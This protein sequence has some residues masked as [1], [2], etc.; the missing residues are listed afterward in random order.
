MGAPE[1]LRPVTMWGHP[2]YNMII[3]IVEGVPPHIYRPPPGRWRPG[4]MWGHP[5]NQG[6]NAIVITLL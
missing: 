3:P 1:Y 4:N 2:G 5:F 6:V